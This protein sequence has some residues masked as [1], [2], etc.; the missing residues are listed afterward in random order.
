L[1]N[2]EGAAGEPVTLY[3]ASYS[4]YVRAVRLVL[5]EKCVDYEHVEVD[6]FGSPRDK[7]AQQARH[8]FG[9]IPSLR[10]GAFELYESGAITRYIDEAF[11]GPA[12]QPPLPRERARLNQMLSILDSYAY[13]ALVWGVYVEAVQKPNSGDQPDGPALKLAM[14]QSDTCLAAL[15]ALA[16]GGGPWLMGAQITLAD[17]HAAPMFAYFGLAPEG[18]ALIRSRPRLSAWWRSAAA[19]DSMAATVL[20]EF[21]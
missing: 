6:V 17:L 12:L 5:A 8:P 16:D 11:P 1:S 14:H 4:V 20:R 3:G 19:L 10:H 2:P 9:R 18:E 21:S 13:R 7:A 15:E